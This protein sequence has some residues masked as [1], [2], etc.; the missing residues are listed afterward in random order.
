M[1]DLALQVGLVDLVEL[2]DAEGAD[3]GRG[4]IEKGRAA[5]A[6]RADDEDLGVLEPL[7]PVHA[8][9]RDDQVPAV[10]TDLVVGQLRCGCDQG[11]Q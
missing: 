10:A 3:A 7:L 6:A 5:Q 9:V 11:W 4:E 8:D 1:D 2:G